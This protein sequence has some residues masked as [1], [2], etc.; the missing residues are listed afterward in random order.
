MYHGRQLL[1][2]T[3]VYVTKLE[4]VKKGKET[5]MLLS[6]L[7][8]AKAFINEK[9]SLKP[10]TAVVLGSGLDSFTNIVVNKESLKYNAIPHFAGC[11]VDGHRG[12]LVAGLIEQVPVMILCGR[13]HCY[14]GFSPEAV[15]FPVRTLKLLGIEN[16]ILTNA[17]GGISTAFSRGDLVMIDD[18]INL[19]G[20]NPLIGPNEDKLGPRFFDMGNAYD[21]DLKAVIRQSAKELN[22]QLHS[23]V[24][25]GVLGPCYETPAE[26]R[27]MRILGGD[28]VGMS[29][30][31]ETIAAKHL[32]L[33][34]AGISCIANEAC[35]E[36]GPELFHEDVQNQ[37][38]QSAK[39]FHALLRKIIGNIG[40]KNA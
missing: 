27:M 38:L 24:Y 32:G 29:T 14:E 11:S 12:E 28:M 19:T 37:V 20:T 40:T 9:F 33:K 16:L 31:F 35:H 34:V 1:H 17:A 3:N 5:L 23:G 10:K 26:T 36:E 25:V 7:K 39:D 4:Y 30:V 6:R 18:H 21:Q 2:K 8:E 22:Y 15:V 13:I